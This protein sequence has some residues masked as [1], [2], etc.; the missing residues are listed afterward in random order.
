VTG[1]RSPVGDVPDR[2]GRERRERVGIV[3]LALAV[4]ALTAVLLVHAESSWRGVL[5]RDG[6]PPASPPTATVGTADHFSIL[7]ANSPRR[8][9]S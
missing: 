8:T 2:T 3:V 7:S 4:G 9:D 5:H 6:L 1:R